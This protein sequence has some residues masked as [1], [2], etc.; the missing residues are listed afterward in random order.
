M[1]SFLLP[2]LSSPVAVMGMVIFVV[3]VLLIMFLGESL[4]GRAEC[5]EAG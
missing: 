2:P 3:G 4:V 5:T 1:S